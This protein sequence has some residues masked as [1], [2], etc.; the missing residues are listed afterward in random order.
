MVIKA[1]ATANVTNTNSPPLFT[2]RAR[3]KQPPQ[4]LAATLATKS[5]LFS[6]FHPLKSNARTMV[7]APC[8]QVR[9]KELHFDY[10]RSENYR[11]ICR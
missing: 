6:I 10:N 3:A 2:P 7:T 8:G 9:V 11:Q 4:R 1:I 5:F